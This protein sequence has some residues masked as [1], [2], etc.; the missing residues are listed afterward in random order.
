MLL[1]SA[2][3]CPCMT[4]RSI[5]GE[6]MESEPLSDGTAHDRHSRIRS[7]W[8]LALGLAVFAVGAGLL[9]LTTPVP[10]DKTVV[11]AARLP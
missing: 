6:V 5:G 11:H 10:M 7:P 2:P 9:L 3:V 1:A 4:F 8:L